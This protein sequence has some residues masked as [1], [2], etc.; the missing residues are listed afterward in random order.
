MILDVHFPTMFY[1]I[2]IRATLATSMSVIVHVGDICDAG[3]Q[4]ISFVRRRG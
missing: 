3:V 2:C 1:G 4:T